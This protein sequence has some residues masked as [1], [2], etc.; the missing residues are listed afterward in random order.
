MFGY[1]LDVKK[2]GT[3]KVCVRAC[4]IHYFLG[5]YRTC[6][7]QCSFMQVSEIVFAR[8]GDIAT[9]VITQVGCVLLCSQITLLELSG[10]PT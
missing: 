2:L 1:E 9:V 10:I 3:A 8:A 7:H 5:H 4:G 6:H